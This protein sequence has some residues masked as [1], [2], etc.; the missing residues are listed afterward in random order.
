LYLLHV[1][2]LSVPA[3]ICL[4]PSSADD[5]VRFLLYRNKAI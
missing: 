3:V 5:L 2:Y 4:K 1:E